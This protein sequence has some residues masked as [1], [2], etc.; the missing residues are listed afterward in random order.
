MGEARILVSA[1]K[2]SAAAIAGGI[3]IQGMKLVI[4]PYID[5][6]KVWGVFSQGFIAGVSGILVYLAFCSLLKSEELFAFWES[7]KRRV[8][9]K[10]ID[11]GDRTE[12]RG[13]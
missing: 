3:A 6:T 7:V 9:W 5:M 8:S 13:V 12:A 2:F 11:T 1:L 10:K 4:W